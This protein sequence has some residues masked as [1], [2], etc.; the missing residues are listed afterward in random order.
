MKVTLNTVFWKPLKKSHFANWDNICVDNH[1]I[2]ARLGSYLF[3]WSADFC[4]FGLTF[5]F[6]MN[7][8][9]QIGLTFVLMICLFLPNCAHICYDNQ[10]ILTEFGLYYLFIL[11]YLADFCQIGLTFSLIISWFCQNLLTFVLIISW[12]FFLPNWTYKN[13]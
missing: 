13:I 12:V 5:V 1:L 2:F 10:L 3:W 8:L 11:Y 6:M 7:F 4:Q 9:Y